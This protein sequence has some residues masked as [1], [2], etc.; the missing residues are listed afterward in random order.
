M[1]GVITLLLIYAFMACTHITLFFLKALSRKILDISI[2]QTNR[3]VLLRKWITIDIENYIKR[4]QT[5]CGQ[6]VAFIHIK[7]GGTYFNHCTSKRKRKTKSQ[8][9]CR[10][11]Q[12][13]T[14]PFILSI[15]L[16]GFFNSCR[17]LLETKRHSPL[18]FLLTCF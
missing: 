2:T 8:F 5:V 18:F 17:R 11:V 7:A 15:N 4:K 1:T 10:S 16:S 13:M 14:F 3:L 6:N 12:N 9:L